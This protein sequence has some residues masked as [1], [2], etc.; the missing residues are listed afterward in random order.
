MGNKRKHGFSALREIAP[1]ELDSGEIKR[2]RKI[3]AA[4]LEL[5]LCEEP[6]AR[7]NAHF[8]LMSCSITRTREN[9]RGSQGD[10]YARLAVDRLS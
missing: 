6:A 3:P 9:D 5:S 10:H 7:S 2:F 8:I 1:Y 4:H